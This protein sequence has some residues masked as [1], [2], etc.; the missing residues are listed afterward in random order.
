MEKKSLA[1]L[2]AVGMTAAIAIPTIAF[3]NARRDSGSLSGLAAVQTPLVAQLAGANEVPVGDPD[4]VGAAAV[5]FDIV[6]PLD[7]TTAGAEVCWDLSQSGIATPTAAHIHLGAAGQVNP[8]LVPL[9][10]TAG[11]YAATGCAPV[12]GTDAAAIVGAPDGY[13]LNIHNA[14]FK[15]G[16][17]RGQLAAGPPPAGEA[18][19]LSVPLRAYDSRDNNGAKI[20]AGETRTISLATGKTGAGLTQIA[21]PPG[22]TAAIVTLTIT[23]TVGNGGFLTMYAATS[24]GLPRIKTW[25][26]ALRWRW[27]RLAK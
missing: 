4:G 2:V 16:A 27:T 22:A 26:S 6:D 8:P 21:V 25:L 10:V 1:A 20:A 13:Y 12:A 7:T 9:E 3:G 18:H 19:L 11:V 17:L 15:T 5:T 14:E 23:K 24:T